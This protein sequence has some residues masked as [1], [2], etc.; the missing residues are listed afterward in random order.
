MAQVVNKQDLANFF[1]VS[2]VSIDR[3]IAKDVP[4]IERG[5]KGVSWKFDLRE[6]AEWYYSG[7]RSSGSS[8]PEEMA[9]VE[10][11][12]WYEGES[13]RQELA[14]KNR[15]LIPRE[16]VTESVATAFATVAQSLLT[17]PDTL[18]RKYSVPPEVA[19]QVQTGISDTLAN[20]KNDM[21]ALSPSL[22]VDDE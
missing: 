3:W 8:D 13:K 2:V 18:E 11:R 6:V 20:L 21:A 19:E 4:F 7:K 14:V 12:A 22:G 10:R 17:I 5:S 1:G 15:E 9:P 16:E